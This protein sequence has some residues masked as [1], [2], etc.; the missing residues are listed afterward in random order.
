M[1]VAPCDVFIVSAFG[2]G[3]WLAVELK[4][5][6]MSVAFIDV[7]A[8][9]GNWPVE[10]ITGPFG[11][12]MLERYHQSYLEYISQIGNFSAVESGFTVWTSDGPIEMK[13]PV[14]AYRFSQMGLHP[15]VRDFLSHYE[16][17]D[18]KNKKALQ[19]ESF[20][21]VWPLN[22]A[23]QLGSTT[24]MSN[25]TALEGDSSLPI[26]QSFLVNRPGRDVF[27][28]SLK[29]VES[30]GIKVFTGGKIVD[31][32]ILGRHAL[33][34]VEIQGPQAGFFKFDNL[35]S[36]ISSEETYFI[37]ERL[38][39][40]LF[41]QGAMECHWSWMRFRLKVE[42]C[43]EISSLPQ[44][45]CWITD[46]MEPWTH[47]NLCLLQKTALLENLDAWVRV[48][49]VQRFNKDYLT[50]LG[51]RILRNFEEKIPLSKPEILTYPQAYYYTYK[52][53]GPPRFPVYLAEDSASRRSRFFKNFFRD[54]FEVWNQFSLD[55]QFD[56]Q[57]QLRNK[58]VDQWQQL[59]I[60][61]KELIND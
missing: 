34:G 25:R 6:G 21:R 23:H 20:Q 58:I 46:V 9:L 29:W 28:R 32:A 12:F 24:Y 15:Q 31:I 33:A 11:L 45:L 16:T 50:N 59:Q 42:N 30:H 2:R 61:K 8:Q 5:S 54:G 3:D 52:D 14:T 38:G 48:P 27:E 13:S 44:H 56:A 41:P 35:V 10:D 53:L 60:K 36:C 1:E 51:A 49:T 17:F 39:K 18:L 22:L 47:E 40:K 19:N 37:D 7:S 57:I 55:H 26:N 43:G 4:K